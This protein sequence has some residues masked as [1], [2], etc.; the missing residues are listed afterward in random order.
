V[1]Y[2]DQHGRARY[3]WVKFPQPSLKGPGF[4]GYEIVAG[5]PDPSR[6]LAVL[7][8]YVLSVNGVEQ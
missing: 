6:P 5:E 4:V 1:L 2:L 8:R 3:A 7:D